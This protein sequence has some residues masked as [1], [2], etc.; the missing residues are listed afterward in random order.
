MLRHA[1]KSKEIRKRPLMPDDRVAN[2]VALPLEVSIFELSPHLALREAIIEVFRQEIAVAVALGHGSARKCGGCGGAAFSPCAAAC[3]RDRAFVASGL[4]Q[5]YC[6]SGVARFDG[7]CPIH[8][9][10]ARC[11][12]FAKCFRGSAQKSRRQLVQLQA[13]LTALRDDMHQ[14]S[15]A[16]QRMHDGAPHLAEIVNS[17]ADALPA[18]LTRA[19]LALGMQQTYAKAR[20]GRKA[21]KKHPS[22][23][24]I[25]DWRKRCKDLRH[26]AELLAAEGL[27][28]QQWLAALTD[29]TRRL[30]Q[31]TDLLALK[32][33]SQQSSPDGDAAKLLHRALKQQLAAEFEMSLALGGRIFKRKPVDQIAHLLTD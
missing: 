30:G 33:W 1:D 4:A 31:V 28:Q 7:S 32:R 26:Q 17:L 20:K 19:Q 9:R 6:N 25:H 24:M 27:P 23:V 13:V 15:E 12:D 11:R 14:S 21:V 29:L 8:K 10:A 16:Q 18:D 2:P 5:S 22:P 3:P